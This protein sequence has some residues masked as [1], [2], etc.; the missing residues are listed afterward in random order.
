MSDLN[1]YPDG[2]EFTG[3]IG[4]TA[5]QSEP[6]WP[7]PPK[8]PEGS[9]NILVML[10]DDLGFAQMGCFGGLGGRVETPSIDRLAAEGIR[11]NNF[12]TTALC[13]PTRAALLTGRN[14]HTAGVG[15][16]METSTGFPGYNGR[17][18]KDTA[19]L[20][21]VLLEYG[22]NTMA[23]GKW[24]LAPD[25]HITAAGPYDRWPLA[26]G[27][28]RFYGFL[29]GE[30]NQWEPDLWHDN[31]KVDPPATPEEGYHLTEDLADRAIEW[32]TAQKVV[33]PSKPFFM[34]FCPGAMHSPHHAPAEYIKRYRGRFDDGWD[35]IRAETLEKQ[36][37]M[38]IVP[39][40]TILPPRNPGVRAWDEL[41]DDERRLFA[42]QMEVYAAFL[43]HTD[44]QVGRVLDHLDRTG[45][46]DDTLV[47]LLSD[48][49]AS[50]EG[51]PVGMISEMS[52]FNMTPESVPEMLARLD[53]WGTYTSHPHYAS[54][55][56]MA[57]NTPNRW[58]KQQVHE[59]GTRDPLIV[60]WP[61]R[62]E[63]AGAVRGQFHHVVDITPT[64][65]EV[66]GL[67]MPDVVRGY[68]QRPVEG[69][70][71]AY[72]LTEPQAPTRKRKQYFEMLSHRAVWADGWKA[73]TT[74]FSTFFKVQY[75]ILEEE[76]HDGFF[77]RDRWELY[78]L[79]EDFSE[80]R[81]LAD[82]HP[83]KLKELIE[84]WW[85]EAGRYNVLPLDD[86][87]VMRLLC[88]KPQVFEERG[89]YTFHSPV[90][91]VRPGSPDVRNRSH[92]I[93]A[94]INVP[95]GGAEGVVVSNGGIDG[96]YA[97]CVMDG[98]VHYVSN[99]LG[100]EHFVVS[101]EKPVPE[102]PVTLRLEFERTD[103]FAGKV[104]IYVNDEKAAEG[105]IPRTNLVVF[106]AA[107]GFEVGSDSTSAV[108]PRYRPP[109][110][111]TGKI[112]E[113]VLSVEGE[114]HRD[115]EAEARVANHQQ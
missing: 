36:K 85:A 100:R 98:R 113:V 51:G 67:E 47:M 26:Q 44:D 24:H 14:H 94:D 80:M 23:L 95:E 35:V 21:A 70:S 79:D 102:G 40:A 109:F 105:D 110:N 53:E 27:F 60:R 89:T 101:C 88:E 9:P 13:S 20:P 59:G 19:M 77:D 54:G 5:N 45:I 62:I 43:T 2:S 71:M 49:G 66:L 64:I 18:P 115:P 22:Y 6:A 31:H 63:D 69:T 93:T 12:H 103:E 11:Y 91:M 37:E 7:V 111:F 52:F 41:S 82:E 3:V 15:S 114:P 106:A 34:Y 65:L 48:N 32:I 29:P 107:E 57:G 55:W 75:G 83:D 84:L 96:G 108:W 78:R 50:A 61:A 17:V 58:Y 81:D 92:V 46:A 33:A 42:R 97:L 56:A 25:E 39:E 1:T 87:V 99:Y 72:S 28:E 76:A 90:R 86:N 16:V 68:R 4:L 104:T 10:L 74:H 8:A 73:V 30:T 112:R 38:G